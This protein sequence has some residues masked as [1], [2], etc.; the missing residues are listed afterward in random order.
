MYIGAAYYPEHVPE[1]RWPQDARLMRAAG[2]NVVRLGEFAWALMEPREG[3]F[4]F[5]WLDQAIAVLA[6]EGILV[7]LGT[8]TA[9]P[10]K[11][12]MDKHP[13]IYLL[14]EHGLVRGFGTR[15]HYCFNA[16]VYHDYTRAIVGRMAAHFKDH[17]QIIAW[18]VDNEFGTHDSARCY[19]ENC[20]R[21][22]QAWLEQKYGTI[23]EV[24]QAWGT[25]FWSQIYNCFDEIILP[26]YS[27]CYDAQPHIWHTLGRHPRIGLH[28]PGLTLDYDR[29][30]SDSVKSYQK[31]QC[32]EIRRH[33]KAMV[34][35]NFSMGNSST[36]WFAQGE[37]L[38]LAA[39]NWYADVGVFKIP[40][41][42]SSMF[43]GMVHSIKRKN[44]WIMEQQSGPAGWMNFGNTPAPGRIRLWTYQSIA[45]GAEAIVYFNWRACP[46][47]TE[48]FWFG[49]LDHDGLPRRRYQEVQ[50]I[51]GELQGLSE[52]FIGSTKAAQAAVL[53]S[54]DCL[55]SLEIQNHNQYLDYLELLGAYYAALATNNMTTDVISI[56]ADLERYRLIVIPAF[57]IASK[58]ARDKL[59]AY[60]NGGG[61][62]VISFRSGV[63]TVT[64]A[65]T[66]QTLPGEFRELA[67]V[68]VEE[69][70]S[71]NA[72]SKID[73]K[74]LQAK[75][76]SV[77]VRGISQHTT[78]TTMAD[79]ALLNLAGLLPFTGK[80]AQWCEV[81]KPVTAEV[82]ATYGSDFYKRRAAITHNRFGRG[83]VYYLGC[84]LDVI[85]LITLLR[86]IL[87]ASGVQPLTTQFLQD[88]EI[89]D[90]QSASGV[91][92][93]LVLNHAES[94]KRIRLPGAYRNLIDNK[95]YHGGITLPPA[96]VAMLVRH[97]P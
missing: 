75:R 78:R 17:P 34:T 61:T 29:F 57:C 87:R 86:G 16:A 6:A 97:N 1:E 3:V 94:R 63:K 53:M 80:A 90:K 35:H 55:W 25:V 79:D 73:L 9:T 40:W 82:L 93:T 5:A 44:F 51:A 56:D 4:D 36:D 18:Q 54:F 8:P 77:K 11:W 95:L 76:R 42:G 67:G 28:N 19:C 2:I 26:G 58:E 47:G 22:F 60:V 64:N 38:D 83:A 92:Y 15:Y 7:I 74:T 30:V 20:R 88:V 49:I 31:L 91:P 72:M 81:L 70:D 32:D 48:Q 23:A 46:V 62:L 69:F 13:E 65:M 68:E 33:S 27:V 85:T 21:A 89:V 24:N 84:D 39:Y 37:D 41:Q 50:A 96:G 14:D 59:E 52:W 10:P 66:T 12:L 45:H 43:L 71:L